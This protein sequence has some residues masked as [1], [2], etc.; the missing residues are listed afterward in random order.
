[1]NTELADRDIAKIFLC[2]NSMIVPYASLFLQFFIK[3]LALT[4]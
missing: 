2:G 3:K 4:C 1:M